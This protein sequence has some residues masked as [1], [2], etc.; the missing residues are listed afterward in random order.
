MAQVI[1]YFPLQLVE[2]EEQ[3]QQSLAEAIVKDT[4]FTVNVW[5]SLLDFIYK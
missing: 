3:F 2:N 1:V 4:D 5:V